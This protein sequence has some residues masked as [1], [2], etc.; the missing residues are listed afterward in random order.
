MI[1][2]EAIIAEAEANAGLAD[3]EPHL[4]RNL[5]ALLASIAAGPP[6]H[7]NGMAAMRRAMTGFTT[8]RLEG[9]RWLRDHPQ[10]GEEAVIAPV[11][12]CGLPRSGTT[13][14]QYL[15]DRDRRFRLLR[16]WEAIMPNPPPGHD[17]A[18]VTARKAAEAEMRGKWK[19]GEI[20]GFDAL[21]LIDEDGSEECHAI[22][23]QAYA[24]AG[25]F[26]LYDAPEFFDFLM[27]GLDL[28]AAYRV[29]KRQLQLL[30]W[31]MPPRR[32][33]LK[34]PNHVIA[35]DAILQVYPD[36]RFAMTHR[37]PLQTLASIAKMT[38]T[39][40]SARYADPVDRTRVG[41]QMLDFVDRHIARIM[42][43]AK[44]PQADRAVH[45]DYYRLVADPAKVMAEVHAGL[46][47]DTPG[48]VREAI[49][50]WRRENPKNKRGANEYTL[51][52]FGIDPGEARERFADYIAHFDIA[53]EAAGTALASAR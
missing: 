49:A 28:E 19:P 1:E 17:P 12:L 29:H 18:S 30:Q 24:T 2:L 48:D 8:N 45:V 41:R 33:A 16:T 7:A 3:P 10:I 43:F 52:Q 50:G 44:G 32:W 35:M 22:L 21:H 4:H 15:F 13:Y 27:D 37:D 6:M 47:I 38:F 42:A 5:A 23:E 26:N 14:F 31:L 51:D 34:Y 39:L 25:S 9:L 53:S 36:A 11:F 40:R 20:E 46:G